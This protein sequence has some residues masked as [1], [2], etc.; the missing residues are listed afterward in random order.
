MRAIRQNIR[1][2]GVSQIKKYLRDRMDGGR[3]EALEHKM[4]PSNNLTAHEHWTRLLQEFMMN[5]EL[6]LRNMKL[7]ELS[8]IVFEK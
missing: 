5:G 3:R 8:S 6:V 7:E 1:A 4:A 2:G